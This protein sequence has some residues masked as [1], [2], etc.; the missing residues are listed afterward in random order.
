MIMEN[1]FPYKIDVMNM[2][3]IF[4]CYIA[5]LSHYVFFELDLASILTISNVA[6]V[7]KI[8]GK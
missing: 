3:N 7:A 6:I 4:L 8:T 2:D 5:K 1:D